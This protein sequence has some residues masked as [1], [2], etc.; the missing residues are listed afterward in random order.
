MKKILRRIKEQY[1]NWLRKR[2]CRAIE[3]F[4]RTMK[5]AYPDGARFLSMIKEVDCGDTRLPVFGLNANFF[6][7][8][9]VSARG[10]CFKE[11]I[12]HEIFNALEERS[13]IVDISRVRIDGCHEAGDFVL[14]L[15]FGY[16][17]SVDKG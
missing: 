5:E 15:R 10:I 4:R 3:K 6:G 7:I 14:K 1:G 9:F 16:L 12:T 17:S 2:R 13:H 11:A 8:G